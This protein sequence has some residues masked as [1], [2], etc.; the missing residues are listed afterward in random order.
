MVQQDANMTVL[1]MALDSFA[2]INL[3]R[4][5][6]LLLLLFFVNCNSKN[7]ENIEK[8]KKTLISEKKVK[9]SNDSLIITI[10]NI[11]AETKTGFIYQDKNLINA[12]VHFEN[13]TKS[14][15]NLTKKIPKNSSNNYILMFRSFVV[16]YN[17]SK[18]YKHDYYI[19]NEIDTINYE[20]NNGD[21]NLITKDEGIVLIDEIYKQYSNVYKKNY[22]S[23][24]VDNQM[25][26]KSFEKLFEENKKIFTKT[27]NKIRLDANELEFLRRL[28]VINGN[29]ERVERYL[30]KMNNPIWSS[31][32]AEIFYNYI[33]SKRD[34][35]YKTDLEDD[36]LSNTFKSLLPI[37]VSWHLQILKDKK[38][39]SYEKNYEWLKKTNYYQLNKIEIEKALKPENKNESLISS[40]LGLFLVKDELGNESNLKK[41]I[42][43]YKSEYYLFDFWASWCAPCIKDSELIHN[44]SLP[45]NLKLINI[46]LD[47]NKDVI[48]WKN[49]SKELMMENN[50]HFVENKSNKEF[51]ELIK[52]NQIPRYILIDKNF[53][54]LD[55]DMISPQE[56]DFLKNLKSY[57]KE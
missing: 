21:I 27:K 46:S 50:Y 29:D 5:K 48:K 19:K 22:L 9:N 25:K 45:N 17:K 2:K 24:N 37:E 55:F 30:K 40:K 23:T 6:Y 54:I 31:S 28:S 43:K 16:I 41:I 4:F 12:Y 42:N 38:Y 49:K 7:K 53:K 35:I 39:A 44:M 36:S 57:I 18:I 15:V 51:I 33:G 32:L 10:N 13:N 14:S 26:I 56:G 8:D 52:L 1:M 34:S 47:K 3:S 20:F 11:P